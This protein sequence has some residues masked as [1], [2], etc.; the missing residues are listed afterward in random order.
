ME[1]NFDMDNMNNLLNIF[2]N[3]V[4]EIKKVKNQ[5]EHSGRTALENLLNEIKKEIQEDIDIIHEEKAE[6][7]KK[8]IPDFSI[9]QYLIY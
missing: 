8:G 2:T 6:D 9:I 1:V 4:N 3:Y 5:S 7:R